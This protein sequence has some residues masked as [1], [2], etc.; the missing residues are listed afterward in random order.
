MAF[1]H[2]ESMLKGMRPTLQQLRSALGA[3]A[4]D[5]IIPDG[6]HAAVAVVITGDL[7][8]LFMRR[9]ERPGDPWSGHVAFPGGHSEPCDRTSLETAIRETHEELGLDLSRAD[10]LGTL[11]D[12]RTSPH[13]PRL[14]VRP[15]VFHLPELPPLRPNHEVASVHRVGLDALLCGE[16]RTCFARDWKG[17]PVTLPCV[18]FEGV[19]LWGMTLGMVDDLLDRL[20]GGGV[21]LARAR[22]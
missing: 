12:V 3:Q 21:G 5:P 10:V 7:R 1:L 6:R 14:T 16:G 11:S 4:P 9:A 2:G 15:W 20:D 8:V 22:G 18:D 17:R 13:L 19:R